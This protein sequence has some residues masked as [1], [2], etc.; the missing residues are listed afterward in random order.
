MIDNPD[1]RRKINKSKQLKKWHTE[2]EVLDK[3]VKELM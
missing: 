1:E 2:M 3:R